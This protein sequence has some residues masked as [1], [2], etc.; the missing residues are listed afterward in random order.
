MLLAN[1][2]KKKKGNILS[3]ERIHSSFQVSIFLSVY[4]HSRIRKEVF[5]PP[6]YDGYFWVL[7]K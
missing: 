3:V 1:E 2:K 4:P 5:C 7:G 6:E